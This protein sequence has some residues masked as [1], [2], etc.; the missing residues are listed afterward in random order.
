MEGGKRRRRSSKGKSKSKKKT[1]SKG[2]SL[3][4]SKVLAMVPADKKARVNKIARGDE[5]ML[6]AALKRKVKV[7][8]KSI[9]FVA[10][11]NKRG[12]WMIQ[13]IGTSPKCVT[14]D[15]KKT[16][17]RTI[18]ANVPKSGAK[19]RSRSRSRSGSKKRKRS[20]SRSGSKKRKRSRSRS[21]S[22]RR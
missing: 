15:G 11:D 7:D 9:K 3:T 14:K 2:K 17:A 16:N 18:V 6:C 5:P 19:A 10:Y 1:G 4:L 8:A 12:R 13:A 20:S 22:K 21:H